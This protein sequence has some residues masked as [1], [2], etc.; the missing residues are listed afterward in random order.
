MVEHA[1][2][3]RGGNHLVAEDVPPLRDGLVGGDEHAAALVAAADELEEQVRGLLLERQDTGMCSL[4]LNWR[5]RGGVTA[6]SARRRS[7]RVH[8]L[9]RL[10][11]PGSQ[12]GSAFTSRGGLVLASAEVKSRRQG[13]LD[14]GIRP[15]PAV[16]TTTNLSCPRL[17]WFA[18]ASSRIV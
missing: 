2:E 15:T 1:V 18:A 14:A 8:V 6:A 3:H 11:N 5:S 13:C 9:H 7:Q 4:A 12:P 16:I 17:I 10:T